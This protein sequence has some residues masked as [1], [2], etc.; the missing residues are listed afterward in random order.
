MGKEW[1]EKMEGIE[2]E[3]QAEMAALEKGSRRMM[4]TEKFPFPVERDG[5]TDLCIHINLRGELVRKTLAE[6][7]APELLEIVKRGTKFQ[8]MFDALV[9]AD[10]AFSGI[11]ID[12]SF[13]SHES[14][15]ALKAGAIVRAILT[16]IKAQGLHETKEAGQ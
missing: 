3:E 15:M 9:A 1:E 11:I 4:L 5:Q 16:I 2:L 7:A 13:P 8:A 14:G 12:D 10:E 6:N